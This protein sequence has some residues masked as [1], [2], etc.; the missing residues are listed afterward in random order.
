MSNGG[1]TVGRWM[2]SRNQ[3]IDSSYCLRVSL[4]RR[5]Y[6]YK[7]S[8]PSAPGGVVIENG[9]SNRTLVIFFPPVVDGCQCLTCTGFSRLLTNPS[10]PVCTPSLTWRGLLLHTVSALLCRRCTVCPPSSS[11][12]MAHSTSCGRPKCFSARRANLAI[13]LTSSSVKLGAVLRSA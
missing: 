9:L 11:T 13:S 6:E 3:N 4:N 7:S 5:W 1:M 12:V 8:Q 2:A 10:T